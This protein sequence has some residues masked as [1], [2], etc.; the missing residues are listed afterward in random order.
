MLFLECII[1]KMIKITEKMYF[2]IINAL[3]YW[4]KLN[5]EI[6]KNYSRGV[7]LHEAFSEIIVGYKYK[8]FLSDD[9]SADLVDL[10]GNKFQVKGASNYKNDLSSFGPRS[11]FDYL[12]YCGLND[13]KNKLLIWKINIDFLNDIYVNRKE[14]FKMQQE[15]KRRPRFSI[16]KKIIEKHNIPIDLEVDLING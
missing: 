5:K 14:T 12:I 9:N 7:N 10:K 2:D 1:L 16:Y 15:A 13:E 4:K 6:K 8:L 3:E 11:K